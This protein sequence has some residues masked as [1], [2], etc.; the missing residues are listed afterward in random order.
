MERAP[1]S[2]R[3]V[4]ARM[5]FDVAGV[6]WRIAEMSARRSGGATPS[7]CLVLSTMDRCVR[8]WSYPSDW[9]LA[10]VEDLLMLALLESCV[11]TAG[12]PKVSTS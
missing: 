7:E 1:H 3:P 6:R 5:T 2:P 4:M 11:S 12:L 9:R 8:L 10:P